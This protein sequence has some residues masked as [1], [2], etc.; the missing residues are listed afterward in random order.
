MEN[1]RQ[2]G[3]T[4]EIHWNRKI[5][6]FS[7]NVCEIWQNVAV[8]VKERHN[9]LFSSFTREQ[10]KFLWA[11]DT[12]TLILIPIW[13]GSDKVLAEITQDKK[14]WTAN[15][16]SLIP[17]PQNLGRPEDHTPIQTRIAKK[18][19]RFKAKGKMRLKDDAELKSKFLE[20]FDWI[21]V[22]LI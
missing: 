4:W 2:C 8:G 7:F 18:S 1:N 3:S 20:R 14:I 15:Q 19:K 5:A 6:L 22:W 9:V 13:P 11:V 12:A 16:H 21:K 17:T 10:T